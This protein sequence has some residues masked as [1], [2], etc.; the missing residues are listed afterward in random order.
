[1]ITVKRNI[2]PF[3]VMLL[4]VLPI[5]TL[6][7]DR[8]PPVLRE[9]GV[10]YRVDGAGNRLPGDP[11]PGDLVA[12]EWVAK[13]SRECPGTVHRTFLSLED[14]SIHSLDNDP[15]SYIARG[16]RLV[17][18]FRVP[19]GLPPGQAIYRAVVHFHCNPLHVWFP[20]V[21]RGPDVYFTVV[22]KMVD[23]RS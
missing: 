17:R 21:V 22:P 10:I 8:N 20:I 15:S 1:M 14:N 11:A 5:G 4:V 16:T 7:F 13:F 2:L 12:V 3:L 9:S 6:L 23:N 19:Y 18:T